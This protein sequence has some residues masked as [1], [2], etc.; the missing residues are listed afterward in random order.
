METIRD[1]TTTALICT[2]SRNARVTTRLL[3]SSGRSG[4]LS[5]DILSRVWS[6]KDETCKL[7]DRQNFPQ[8]EVKIYQYHLVAVENCQCPV[9][10]CVFFGSYGKLFV[11]SR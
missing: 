2:T 5:K 3:D 4:S 6:R 1:S 7:K 10:I 8:L 11:P 9:L